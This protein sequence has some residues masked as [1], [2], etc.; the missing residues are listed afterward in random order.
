MTPSGIEPASS[1]LATQC[2]KKVRYRAQP[3]KGSV[4]DP[5]LS[6]NSLFCEI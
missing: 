3:V 4:P 2:P 1:R 6:D 5:I